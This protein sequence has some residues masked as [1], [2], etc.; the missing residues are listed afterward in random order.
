MKRRKPAPKPLPRPKPQPILP[1]V[2]SRGTATQ[3]PIFDS[4]N[5]DAALAKQYYNN[6]FQQSQQQA[7][8]FNQYLTM[9][10]S[11]DQA[12]TF[13]TA[14]TVSNQGILPITNPINPNTQAGLPQNFN[15]IAGQIP[16][17]TMG[18][19][20]P[21]SFQNFQNLVQN[22]VAQAN[23]RNMYE[24]MRP[25]VSGVG[26]ARPVN[27]NAPTSQFGSGLSGIKKFF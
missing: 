4:P 18:S 25:F 22:G 9:G 11:P 24:A 8:L 7:D 15:Q 21:S 3:V 10:S 2:D 5:Y 19:A 6:L 27:P 17:F 26:P 12:L 23:L 13:A 14:G 20:N 16:K 1:P